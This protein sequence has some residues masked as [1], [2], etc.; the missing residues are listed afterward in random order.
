M[1]ELDDIVEHCRVWAK[2][3][4]A[5]IESEAIY[6][7]G[8]AIHRD[9]FQFDA[10]RSDLDLVVL[11]PQSLVFAPARTAWLLRLQEHKSKLEA[12]LLRLLGRGDATNPIV[13]IVAATSAEVTRDVHKSGVRDFF[14]EN[15]FKNLGHSANSQ[16][17]PLLLTSPV[18]TDEKTRQVLGFVQGI[19]NKFLGISPSGKLSLPVWNDA[20]DPLPKELMRH[21]AIA[22]QA[23]P[24]PPDPDATFDTQFGLD[25]LFH[26]LYIQ[27]EMDRKYMELYLWLSVRRGARGRRGALAPEGYLF[28]AEVL[29]D[30]VV[31]EGSSPSE[32]TAAVDSRLSPVTPP[33]A[34][35]PA[36][37]ATFNVSE[38]QLISGSAE[39]I[40]ASIEEATT[41][42]A[43]R[44]TPPL[45]VRM[46]E[47]EA[48]DSALSNSEGVSPKER[49]RRAKA[50]HRRSE[51]VRV[52]PTLER[53]LTDLLFYQHVLL[54]ER[55]FGRKQ[56]RYLIVAM[57]VFTHR[58][59]QPIPGG[60][61]QA[62]K[63]MDGG[64]QLIVEFSLPPAPGTKWLESRLE[65]KGL[66][67]VEQIDQLAANNPF[68][69]ELPAAFIAKFFIPEVLITFMNRVNR[70]LL[71]LKSVE[72]W[73]YAFSL[74]TWRFGPR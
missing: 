24:R 48:L 45:V 26:Y 20:S 49:T 72:E 22:R 31:P 28:L 6:L 73:T 30:I 68:V 41:N 1:T 12:S 40:S 71:E 74:D 18:E 50:I 34:L 11:I 69:S 39:E 59:F 7:F 23:G 14:R 54:P 3:V 55:T 21:A 32:N 33:S 5:D 25:E 63:P 66:N 8:S 19:R 60:F 17:A 43:W 47:L 27:R 10:A 58:A 65:S 36:I 52:K 37:A 35:F 67:Y 46:T 61:F 16:E 56:R 62:W 2:A 9:G 15:K 53:G 57:Q 70:G 42:L 44:R 4:Q 38:R 51:L 29:F 64:G 13:S